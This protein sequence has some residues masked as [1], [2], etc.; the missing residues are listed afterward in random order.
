MIDF[1]SMKVFGV[2]EAKDSLSR[3]LNDASVGK[4]QFV[5]SGDGTP[6][7][8]ISVD[9]LAEAVASIGNQRSVTVADA[10]SQ[11]PYSAEELVPV[12][13]SRRTPTRGIVREFATEQ[14]S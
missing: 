11:L 7:L 14:E 2:R 10:I 5:A 6:V 4:M 3:L 8:I 12:Q 13:L 1:A 9:K